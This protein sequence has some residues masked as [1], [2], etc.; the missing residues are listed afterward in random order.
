M[1][2]WVVE[3]STF[4]NLRCAY[5]YQWDGL[6][7]RRRM[8]LALWRRV[9]QAACD[10]HLLQQARTSQPVH[11]RIIWHGGEPL[12]LPLD[13]LEATFEL[14]RQVAR[15]AGIPDE[16]F[17]TTM[18]TN[19]YAVS[20]A[21]VALLANHNV[22]FGVSFDLV[23]GVRLGVGGRPSEDRVLRNLDRLR[24]AGLAHGAITV[25]ARH[26]APMICDVFDFWARRDMS[27]RVLPLFAGP[28]GRDAGLFEADESELVAALCRLFDHWMRSR[29]SITV[30]PLA[31]WLT[32]VIRHQ[33]GQQTAEYD[34]RA[35]GES[36]LCVRPDG[37]LFLVAEAGVTGWALGDLQSQTISQ[38]LAGSAYLASL[39]RTEATTTQRCSGCR[40]RGACDGWPAH[41][42]PV[43]LASDS[44]CHVAYH[45]QGYI[46]SYLRGAGLTASALRELLV[47]GGSR[48][49]ATLAGNVSLAS[50]VR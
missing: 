21:M 27:F 47:S 29:S 18:Q 13:Y 41:T 10:Y 14:H 26:T 43:D 32:T 37:T 11:T 33:L 28:P 9:L 50:D 46:D 15:A 36:V 7:D 40:F 3:A 44:R 49:G 39:D 12:T 6:S 4:C 35:N 25:L 16:R 2:E 24:E 23:R 19:L 45:V 42:A 1:I 38:I 31:E 17:T 34:R 48:L 8:P 20:D 30:E 5:C 22:G